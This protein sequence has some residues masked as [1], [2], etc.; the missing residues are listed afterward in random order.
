MLNMKRTALFL[1]ATAALLGAAPAA[2]QDAGQVGITMGYPATIGVLW[3]P[4]DRI[5]LR[6]EVSLTR[7]TSETTI[8]LST[9]VFG[10]PR[11][12]ESEVTTS[13][14][15]LVGTGVSALFYLVKG[16]ALRTYVSPRFTYARSSSTGT[17][18][19]SL[20]VVIAPPTT[21]T[22]NYGV[23]GSV[24]AQYALAKRFGV[25]GEVGLAYARSTITPNSTTF[26][27]EGKNTTIGLR[28]GVGV[29]LYFR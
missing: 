8:T 22:S 6:P 16:D 25:F 12:S 11:V 13:E 5:G 27:S 23:S 20:P 24:G 19:V 10:V 21:V 2:A 1:A 26:R 28:S 15:W 7:G 4:S 29:V 9:P 3:H 18:F 17:T 14:N